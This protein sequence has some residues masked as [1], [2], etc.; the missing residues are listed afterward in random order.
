MVRV[1]PAAGLDWLAASANGAALLA[2]VLNALPVA[3]YMTDAAG[4][5]TF[6]NREAASLWG[7]D[8]EIGTAEWCGSWRLYWPDG[9][10][11]PHDK[12]PMAVALMERRPVRGAE[13]TAERP[14]GTRVRFLAYPTPLFDGETMLGAV[15]MLVQIGGQADYFEQRLSAIVECSEDAI[16]SKDLS[17]VI[18]TWNRA[19]ERLFGYTAEEAVGRPIMMLIP[20]DRQAEEEAILDSIRRGKPVARYETWRQRKDGSLVPIAL[21]VSPLRDGSG[22]IIGASKIARDITSELQM[23]EQQTLVLN[24]M[25]HRLK[26]VLAVAGGLIG[27]SARSAQSPKAMAKAVQERLG[28]YSRAHELTRAASR[29]GAINGQ[30]TLHALI[31]AITGPY[32]VEEGEEGNIT[33]EGDDVAIDSNTAASLALVLHEFTTNAA[34]HGALSVPTGEVRIASRCANGQTEL[35]WTERGGPRIEGPPRREGFGSLLAVRTVEGQL[36]GCL[37]YDWQPYGVVIKM[38]LPIDNSDQP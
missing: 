3:V 12:C 11:M 5:I 4:R 15:N 28:A 37:R 29:G 23:R 19:A 22:R 24:E 10:V 21:T 14:D 6:Y 30:T 31:H 32:L 26:N 20:R 16:V 13:A 25:G 18:T 38:I 33:V 34:K 1:G 27:L 8:P 7:Y 2:S 9:R 17:G 35:E 36:N